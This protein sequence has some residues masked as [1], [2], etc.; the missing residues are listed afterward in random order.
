VVTTLLATEQ[1]YVHTLCLVE[2]Q[3]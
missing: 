3:S 1:L 2:L